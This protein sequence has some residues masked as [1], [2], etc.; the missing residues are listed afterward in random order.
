VLREHGSSIEELIKIFTSA[1][2]GIFALDGKTPISM[3]PAI[4]QSSIP[5]GSSR[6]AVA[7]PARRS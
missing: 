3:D 1:G 7:L 5:D 4:L 2:Y 6:N